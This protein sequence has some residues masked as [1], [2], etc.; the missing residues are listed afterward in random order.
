[1]KDEACI[2]SDASESAINCDPAKKIISE[3][4]VTLLFR[5]ASLHCSEKEKAPSKKGPHQKNVSN[6]VPGVAI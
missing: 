2:I 1:M 4:D 3:P 6:R 5:M